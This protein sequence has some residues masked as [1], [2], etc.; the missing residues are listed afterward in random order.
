MHNG[1]GKAIRVLLKTS[2]IILS[3][4]FQNADKI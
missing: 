1:I 2:Y 4:I 3:L